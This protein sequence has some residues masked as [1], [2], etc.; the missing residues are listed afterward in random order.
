MQQYWGYGGFRALQEDIIREVY[1]GRDVLALMPTGGGK[2][3]TFQV[4]AL[5]KDGI[6]LVVTPLIA[7][8]KDQVESLKKRGIKALAIYSGMTRREIDIAFDNA[9]YGQYKFLYLSPERLGT[10]LFQM[11]VQKM[12]VNLLAV[13]EAHCISQWG[14]DFRPS[15]MGIAPARK[16]L[17]GVPV[18]AVTATATP[19]VAQDIMDKL[20]FRKPNLLQKSFERKNLIYVVRE[21]EDKNAQLLRICNNVRGTGIVYVR[22]RGNTQEIAAFLNDNHISADYYHAGLGAEI[23]SAKQDNWKRDR[24]RVMVCTNAFGMGIDKPGVRFVVHVDLPDSMEAYFQE[25]GRGG[26]DEKTAYAVLLYNNDDTH[27][28]AQ[29]LRTTFPPVETIREVYQRIYRYFEIPYGA[30]KGSVFNFSLMDFSVQN[31]IHSLTAYNALQCLQREGYLELTDELDNPARIHFTVTRDEL[32]KVQINNEA[33]DRFIR[34]L[35]RAYTGIFTNFVPIDELYLAKLMNADTAVINDYLLRLSRMRVID[36]IPKK[37]TPLLLFNEERL[38]EGNLRISKEHYGD[39]KKRHEQRIK[40]ML[41]YA[42][43]TAQCRSRQLLAYFGE[44]AAPPCGRCD[45][46]TAQN[47]ADVSN[48]KFDLLSG[49]LKTAIREN[50]FTLTQCINSIDSN[51]DDTIKVLRWLIDHGEVYETDEGIYRTYEG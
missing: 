6:C 49:K 9:V 23:R 47:A 30:G 38:D 34:C 51:P 28:A 1:E 32:Y 46:C 10:E 36:Y 15:Y 33:L 18:L 37:R 48:Y 20:G 4:P 24:T 27:K 14:Y 16:W 40:A 44:T 8:M 21:A 41:H 12:N 45:V 17:P 31:K 3:I 29:R 39:L 11:R 42:A 43:N 50:S 5:A 7:L 25:A 2:S 26:R 35:L 13:D 22:S 19:Q